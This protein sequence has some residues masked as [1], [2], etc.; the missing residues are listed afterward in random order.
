MAAQAGRSAS[1]SSGAVPRTACGRA[2]PRGAV[3]ESALDC[4]I[5]M[6]HEGLIVEFNPA[7]EAT[8]GYRQ[9]DV[10]GKPLADMIIPPSL[11]ERHKAG[12]AHFK[13]TGESHVVG[14]RLLMNGMRADGSEFPVELAVTRI[15]LRIR[16]CSPATCATSRSGAR[17]RRAPNG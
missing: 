13:E 1:S 5:T 9:A 2:K 15:G 10:V 8:F 6:N 16:R 7:A 14:R 3:L 11:R 4:V 12:L 17:P